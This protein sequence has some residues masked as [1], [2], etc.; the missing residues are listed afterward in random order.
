[1]NRRYDSAPILACNTSPDTDFDNKN[2]A[3]TTPTIDAF[4]N[5]AQFYKPVRV[6]APMQGLCDPQMR[7]MLGFIA[8]QLEAP[9]DWMVSEFVRVTHHVLTKSVFYRFVPELQYGGK[10]KDGTPVHVQLLGS[11]INNLAKSAKVALSCGAVAIDLNFG[12]PAKTVNA[13]Q[14]GAVLLNNPALIAQIISAVKNEVHDACPVSVKIRLGYESDNIEA[15]IDAL[16]SVRPDWLC[17]HAR[18]KTQGYKPPAHWVKIANFSVLNIPIIANGDIFST[19][20]AHLCAKNA[21][22]P[23]LMLGRGAVMRPDLTAQLLGKSVLSWRD[24]VAHQIEFLSEKSVHKDAVLGRYKQW[25]NMLRSGYTQANQIWP[26]A[27]LI[28]DCAKMQALLDK[29]VAD[30]VDEGRQLCY[31]DK[32]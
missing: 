26:V 10:T 28:K 31:L 6:L 7:Q 17:V 24:L 1:M 2:F 22:T 11:D 12:C 5:A 8:R 9:F 16:Q 13:H 21:N 27:R 23:H 20:D 32:Y 3:N 15:L 4:C 30:G 19:Q 18:T 25:L 29:S 14:G